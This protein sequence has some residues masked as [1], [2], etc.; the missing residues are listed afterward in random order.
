MTTWAAKVNGIKIHTIEAESRDT[1]RKLFTHFLRD[2]ALSDWRAEGR[3]VVLCSDHV[4]EMSAN[5]QLEDTHTDE[6]ILSHLVDR[7]NWR[8]PQPQKQPTLKYQFPHAPIA[9]VFLADEHIGSPGVRYDVLLNIAQ[10]ISSTEGMYCATLGDEIDNFIVGK[11]ALVGALNDD[12]ILD[13]LHALK[14]Y[15]RI[16]SRNNSLLFSIAGNHER[17]TV[18]QAGLDPLFNLMM[19]MGIPYNLDEI[20]AIFKVGNQEYRIQA[21]HQFR[22]AS[23]YHDFQPAFNLFDLGDHSAF[24]DK[25][26]HIVCL[27]HRHTFAHATLSRQGLLR[28]FIITGSLKTTDDYVRKLGFQ[29]ALPFMPVCIL[30]P[31]KYQVEIRHD[32]DEVANSYLPWVRTKYK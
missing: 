26:P 25:S 15:I 21:R 9:F 13:Q 16:L 23:K 1:A 20:S 31:D 27:G 14:A 19:E 5:T 22:G 6:E 17:W 24:E 3:K 8:P 18:A 32:I 11:L 28:H 10:T 29:D 7:M 4:E 12:S 30:Y 2:P